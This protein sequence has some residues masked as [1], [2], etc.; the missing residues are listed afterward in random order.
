LAIE[1]DIA[2]VT[3][4]LGVAFNSTFIALM[5]SMVVMFFSHQLQLMQERQVLDTQ[6]YCDDK[7]LRH[8]SVES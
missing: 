4:N 3:A 8:L 6:R 2:G 7:L 1:G 5:I